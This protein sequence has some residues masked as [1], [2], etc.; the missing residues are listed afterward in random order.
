MRTPYQDEFRSSHEVEYPNVGTVRKA[1]KG[2]AGDFTLV[3][4]KEAGHSKSN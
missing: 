1:G 3:K 4:I 2:A